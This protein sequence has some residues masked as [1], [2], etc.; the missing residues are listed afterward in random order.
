MNK[1]RYTGDS[2]IL[3]RLC[4]IVNSLVDAVDDHVLYETDTAESTF[5]LSEDMA[6]YRFLHITARLGTDEYCSAL[7]PTIEGTHYMGCSILG[8]Y[9]EGQLDIATVSEETG[10]TVTSNLSGF[11]EFTVIKVVGFV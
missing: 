8:N 4:S 3:L 1:I 7:I 2:K 6:G 5:V 10:V 9:A 11:T